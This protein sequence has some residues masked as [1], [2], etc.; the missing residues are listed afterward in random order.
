MFKKTFI[1]IFMLIFFVSGCSSPDKN[2]DVYK[3]IIKRDKL[4]VGVQYDAKPF[5]FIDA[6]GKLKGVD[7]D[8]ARELAKRILGDEN[9]VKF[10]QVAPSTRIQ[11]VTAGDVDVV[12]ATMSI[13]P[14]RRT[15]VDFSDPY[16]I[17]GQ[18]IVV[19][20]DSDITTYNDLNNKNVIVVLGTTGERNLRYFVPS[21]IVQGYK[22]YAEAFKAFKEGQADAI[23]TDDSLL[24]GFVMD[25]KDYKIL[26]KRFTQEPYGI[27]FKNSED[28][29]SLKVNINRI[30]SDMKSDG[31]L[32]NIKKKWNVS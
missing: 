16:F 26:P 2:Q 20:L 13:T 29:A 12:I 22:N 27:A 17:A 4:I 5:G 25:N 23:T 15:I 24:M 31:T 1:I 11:A 6:D 9:K 30:L 32:N 10:K 14:Q 18:A 19:P 3:S 8:I 7:V 28:A 21:A